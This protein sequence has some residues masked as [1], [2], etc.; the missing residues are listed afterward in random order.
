MAFWAEIKKAINSNLDKPLNVLIDEKSAIKSVQRGTCN[1]KNSTS[2][3]VTINNVNS[4]KTV[5]NLLGVFMVNNE[6]NYT[7]AHAGSFAAVS[8]RLTSPTA[9]VLT[10]LFAFSPT[11]GIS[12]EVIE[13]Y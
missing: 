10:T 2:T 3:T 12:Y 8:A 11:I 5:V 9:L 13:F 6:G 4:N 7:Y 1:I